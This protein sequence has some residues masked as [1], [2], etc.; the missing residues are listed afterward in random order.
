MT[1]FI[2][3]VTAIWIISMAFVYVMYDRWEDLD[4]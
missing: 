1:I 2:I 3:I 4:G